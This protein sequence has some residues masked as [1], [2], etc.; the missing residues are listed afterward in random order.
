MASYLDGLSERD[1]RTLAGILVSDPDQLA[2]ELQTRPWAIHDI[3]SAEDVFAGVMGRQAH[4]ANVVSPFLLFAVMV[5][6]AAAELRTAT[7][8]NDWV[9]PRS[10]LP[11]FDVAPLQEFIEAPSRLFFLVSLLESF[12]IPEPPPVPANPLDL[13]DMAVWLDQALPADRATLLRKL[14]DLSLFLTGVLPDHTGRQA[15]TPPEAERLGKTVDMT[16]DEILRLCDKASFGPGLDAFESLGSRWYETA[17]AEGSAP[18]LFGD[19]AARFRAARRV[20]NHVTD[21]FL[22]EIDCNWNLAA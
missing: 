12:A 2:E 8:V 11:V 5:H 22:F 1:L 7:F 4:P 21:R 6:R 20:L 9:G 18:P 13:A 14:G 17:V 16:T 19:V 3:L 15:L 10:R